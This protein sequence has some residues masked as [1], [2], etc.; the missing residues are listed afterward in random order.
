LDWLRH[1]HPY[2]Q[3]ILRCVPTRPIP[4]AAL[5][6]LGDWNAEQPEYPVVFWSPALE[7]AAGV[8]DQLCQRWPAA[9]LYTIV[10]ASGLSRLYAARLADGD[11]APAMPRAQW[12]VSGCPQPRSRSPDT[13]DVASVPVG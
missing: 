5:E 13:Y 4:L 8:T 3:E 1:H 12:T 6:R 7:Q 9:A 10:D 2:I 11:W